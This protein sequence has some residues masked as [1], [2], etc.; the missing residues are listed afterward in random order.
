MRLFDP[1]LQPHERQRQEN[2]EIRFLQ[3]AK[4]ITPLTIQSNDLHKASS[5]AIQLDSWQKQSSQV[6][7]TQMPILPLPHAL[8]VASSSLHVTTR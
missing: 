6:F 1:H 5:Q 7:S 4:V 2:L 8:Q 3:L